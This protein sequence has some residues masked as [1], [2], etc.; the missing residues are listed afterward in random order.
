MRKE[1]GVCLVTGLC[2]WG[3]GNKHMA[4]AMFVTGIKILLWKKGENKQAV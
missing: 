1:D 3:G 2:S 4:S